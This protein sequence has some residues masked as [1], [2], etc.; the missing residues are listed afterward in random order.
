MDFWNK[1]LNQEKMRKKESVDSN[2]IKVE[3]IHQPGLSTMFGRE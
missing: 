3:N 1:H 2:K